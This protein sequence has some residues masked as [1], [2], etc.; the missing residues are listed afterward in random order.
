ML[1][2]RLSSDIEEKLHNIAEIFGIPKS[3]WPYFDSNS[4]YGFIES[5]SGAL[6]RYEKEN[7]QKETCRR[8]HGMGSPDH[9]LPQ[10]Q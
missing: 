4:Y 3:E 5:I 6:K 7:A 8:I 2:L 10:Q 1:T 9:H